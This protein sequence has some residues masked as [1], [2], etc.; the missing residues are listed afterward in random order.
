M[1]HKQQGRA[2]LAAE[3]EGIA[4]PVDRLAFSARFARMALDSLPAPTPAGR[5]VSN[6]LKRADALF[7]RVQDGVVMGTQFADDEMGVPHEVDAPVLS[8]DAQQALAEL[9]TLIYPEH[10]DYAAAHETLDGLTRR[11]EW[12][13]E[14]LRTPKAWWQFWR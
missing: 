5:D 6:V 8:S 9:R 14:Q 11:V 1:G 12:A 4:S 10:R 3:I 13:I 2:K 7:Q